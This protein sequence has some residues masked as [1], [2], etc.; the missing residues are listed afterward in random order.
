MPCG[1]GKFVL[2]VGF[3]KALK[4]C[5]VS[6]RLFLAHGVS[7]CKLQTPKF[8]IE[9]CAAVG[10]VAMEREELLVKPNCFEFCGL[11]IGSSWLPRQKIFR[12]SE[13]STRSIDLK[14]V[15][16]SCTGLFA[17]RI[18]VDRNEGKNIEEGWAV[19]IRQCPFFEQRFIACDRNLR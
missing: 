17:R 3:C 8:G 6:A 10:I 16:G 11:R 13:G 5:F 14:G 19:A 7:V 12:R 15:F 2:A 1:R 18:E 9:K 4:G